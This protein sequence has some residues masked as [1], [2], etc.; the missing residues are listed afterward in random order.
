MSELC[1]I[2]L[3]HIGSVPMQ[4]TIICTM[5]NNENLRFIRIQAMAVWVEHLA[6]S[7]FLYLGNLSCVCSVVVSSGGAPTPAGTSMFTMHNNENLRFIRIQ[8]M[9]VWVEHLALSLFLYLGNLSCVCS[10]VVSSGGAPTP[11]STSMFTM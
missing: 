7:L 11:A 2:F 9:A 10:V 5:H 1:G 6:L 4:C 3:L 8:A